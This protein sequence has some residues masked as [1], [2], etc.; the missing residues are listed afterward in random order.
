MEVGVDAGGDLR[1][2][3]DQRVHAQPRLPVELHQRGR[4]V[5]RD[6]PEGVNAEAFHRPVGAWDAPVGHVPDGVR[7][8][9]GVQRDEVPER[10]VRG[11]GLWDFAIRMRLAGVDDVGE[12]DAVLDEEHRHVVADQIERALA[13]VELGGESA[14][15]AHGVRRSARAQHRGEPD[16]HRRLDTGFEKLCRAD[17]FGRAIPAKYAVGAGPTGVHN[18]LGNAFVVEVGDLFAQ[19]E[20]LQKRRPAFARLQRM[21]GVVEPHALGG[22][23]VLVLLA[24]RGL[25]AL[26]R[27]SG[28]GA[29]FRRDLIR[30]GRQRVTRCRRLIEIRRLRAGCAGHIAA[31][32]CLLCLALADQ[33]LATRHRSD[34]LLGHGLDAFDDALDRIGALAVLRHEISLM[35]A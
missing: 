20:V 35:G 4:V 31:C 16:E 19:M 8:G 23:E 1:L 15:I 18:A 6:Q 11:L 30:L 29:K 24:A 9:F 34:G 14:G 13:G 33:K 21:I 26:H 17:L 12:L 10:V 2:L 3:P 22:G 5:R 25:R 7:R 32:L 28:C 27:R